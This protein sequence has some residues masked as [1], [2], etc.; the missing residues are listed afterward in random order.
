V[1]RNGEPI[2]YLSSGGYGYTIGRPV[3]L[4]YLRRAEGVSEDWALS[5]DYELVIAETR[6]PAR[7]SFSP[8]YDPKGE[9]P[10]L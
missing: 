10:R 1:L 5:G 7:V 3:G 8:L 4:G 9:R 6:S 2:G